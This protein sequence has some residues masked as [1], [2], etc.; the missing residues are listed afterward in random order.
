MEL[1]FTLL[2][3]YFGIIIF[4]TAFKN[5]NS[6]KTM[7]AYFFGPV[8]YI[9]TAMYVIEFDSFELFTFSGIGFLCSISICS[10]II[11]IKYSFKIFFYLKNNNFKT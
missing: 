2:G 1:F 10:C 8:I 6:F 7:I 9:E 5:V 4:A 11:F 3:L